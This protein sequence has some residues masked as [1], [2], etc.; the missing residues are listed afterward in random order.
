MTV[1]MTHG[2]RLG[3]DPSQV[4]ASCREGE[5]KEEHQARRVHQAQEASSLEGGNRDQEG[6][7]DGLRKA[8]RGYPVKVQ[9]GC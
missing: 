1:Q 7:A 8:V 9:R 4:E 2:N 3:E 5:G 6:K